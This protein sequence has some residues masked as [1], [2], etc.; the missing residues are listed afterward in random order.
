LSGVRGHDKGRGTFR[1][2]QN[3]IGRMGRPIEEARF[4]PIAP[5]DPLERG[6]GRWEAYLHED[7]PDVLVQLAIVHA[8][9]ESLHPFLE[10]NGRIGRML[11]PLFLFS[12]DVLHEP[13]FYMSAYL[14]THKD[15]Y[16]DRLLAVSQEDLW[17]DW[18]VFFLRA[19]IEQATENERK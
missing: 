15:E 6:M 7:S 2:L 14:E 3:Y 12:R 11:I 17:T 19:I 8:E 16:C 5:G 1:Q 13:M 10:G 9:F 4:V 18:C